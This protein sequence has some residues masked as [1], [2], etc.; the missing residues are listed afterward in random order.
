MDLTGSV[1]T[2]RLSDGTRLRGELYLVPGSLVASRVTLKA[3]P[4]E[5][6]NLDAVGITATNA[7][8]SNANHI[9]R[10]FGPAGAEARVMQVESALFLQ[11]VPG[12][13]FDIDSFESN[14]AL[15]VSELTGAIGPQGYADF[16]V[17]LRKTDADGG[18]NVFTAVTKQNGKIGP[19][20][21]QLILD[22][23]P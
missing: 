9:V 12:G 17:T 15:S 19:T 22:Y 16:A 13:G 11:G 8:V 23:Q 18:I 21:G 2:A 10:V 20:G 6:P 7:P 3:A 4:P 14:T 1:V 5:R